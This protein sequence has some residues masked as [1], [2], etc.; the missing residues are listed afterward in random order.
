ML[1]FVLLD[2]SF[3]ELLLEEADDE[4]P[5]L[6]PPFLRRPGQSLPLLLFNSIF[7]KVDGFPCEDS[8]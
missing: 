2:R 1:L 3:E 7:H 4:D 5:P 6:P 8:I